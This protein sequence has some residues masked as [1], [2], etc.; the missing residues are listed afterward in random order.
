MARMEVAQAARDLVHLGPQLAGAPAALVASGSAHLRSVRD[1]LFDAAARRLDGD[2]DYE[3]HL[4]F[5][6][7][8]LDAAL[9]LHEPAGGPLENILALP[10]LGAL[11]AT[12]SLSGPRSAEQLK[13]ALQAGELKRQAEGSFKFNQFS[14]ELAVALSTAAPDS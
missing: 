4:H 7:Q 14:A 13:L 11:D 12:L 8:R 3:L 2:G 6:A 10:G 9:K 5:D 1:M